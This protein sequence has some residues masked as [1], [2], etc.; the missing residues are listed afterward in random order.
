VATLADKLDTPQLV[1]ALKR[2]LSVGPVRDRLLEVQSRRCGQSFKNVWDL[3]SWLE[4]HSPE[5]D[6]KA[7]PV[8]HQE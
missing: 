4:E 6:L 2:P 5:I 3:V 1:G 7:P 8:R